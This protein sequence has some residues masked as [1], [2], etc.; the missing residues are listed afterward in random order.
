MYLHICSMIC[1][2]VS[3]S[4]LLTFPLA[5]AMLDGQTAV[6]VVHALQL[7]LQFVNL[8]ADKLGFSGIGKWNLFKLAVTDYHNVIVAGGDFGTKPFTV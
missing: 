5:L 6:A 1:F 8:L 2:A 3:K 7:H 4:V